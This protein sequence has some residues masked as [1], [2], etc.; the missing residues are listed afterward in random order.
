MPLRVQVRRE[1]L[2]TR[3]LGQGGEHDSD[4][5]LTNHQNG[6][7]RC[8]IEAAHALEAGIQRLDEHGLSKRDAVRN[9]NQSAFH[10]P[11]HDPHVAGEAA[12]GGLEPRTAA[13]A[14]V[15]RTLGEGLLA[16]VVAS[17]ARDVVEH[18]HTVTYGER[19]H[20]VSHG[21]D[22]AYRFVAEDARRGVRSGVNLF[23]VSAANATSMNLDQHF[24]RPD[25]RH[26]NGLDTDIVD[27]AVHRGL[28]G[29]GQ[30]G[31]CILHDFR[32]CLHP[33]HLP[34]PR[35]CAAHQRAD[36]R[37]HGDC[38][39]PAILAH[40]RQA[41][42]ITG[43]DG[44]MRQKGCEPQ[45]ALVVGVP[46]EVRQRL[47]GRIRD[48]LQAIKWNPLTASHA[49]DCGCFHIDQDGLVALPEPPLFRGKGHMVNG[50]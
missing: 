46:A 3:A 47:S 40:T 8:K 29:R 1:H 42:P 4:W 48:R 31:R 30:S 16:A 26:R 12:A 37:S 18:S 15:N 36:G 13:D 17:P 5:A 10:D 6:F 23:Q 7:V 33:C 28:H 43:P 39:S 14:L 34:R 38:A 32:C 20:S 41:R 44:D 49:G 22:R 24:S 21:R 45:V 2:C 11:V 9:L 25:R 50:Y 19:F 27:A 35:L